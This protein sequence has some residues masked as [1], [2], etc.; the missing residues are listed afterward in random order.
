MVLDIFALVGMVSLGFFIMVDGFISVIKGDAWYFIFTPD[1]F[2][3]TNNIV[4]I[5]QA[6]MEDIKLQEILGKR[7]ESLEK[8]EAL[9]KSW[10]EQ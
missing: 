2:N 5:L 6:S 8:M 10:G 1:G 4:I 3:T 7:K 9:M